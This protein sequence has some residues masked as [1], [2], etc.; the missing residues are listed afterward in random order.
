MKAEKIILGNIVTLD[1]V[2]PFAK[3]L[4]VADG[5]IQYVGSAEN[6]KALCDENT[7]V[8]DYG[9]A[10]IYPGFMDAHVHPILAGY[11]SLG[12]GDLSKIPV[13]DKEIY[14]KEIT[15]YIAEH[16]DKD[17]YLVAGWEEDANTV[18][19]AEYLDEICPDKPLLLNT[20]AGHSIL[21]N[22]AAI[23][24]YGITKEFALQQ[25]TDLVRVDD[26]GEP[27]G[28]ICEAPCAKLIE[29]L[30]I[31]SQEAKDYILHW[32][33]YAFSKGFTG[34][35][36]AGV[37]LFLSRMQDVYFDL[38]KEGALKLYTFGYMLT[39]DNISDP[40]GK[41]KE[42]AELR[43]A[44]PGEHFKIVGAK[45]FLDGIVEA[46]T[47]WLVDDYT[48]QPGYHGNERFNDPQKLT[49]L[50]AET[51]RYGLGVHAHSIGDGATRFFLDCVEAGQKLS[52][53]M[54]QRNALSHLQ[55]V[56]PEDIQ[57]MA[58]T[59]TVAVV[60]PLWS[61]TYPGSYE[62]EASYI[63]K[64]R[65]D[66]SFPIRSFFD[67]GALTVF[68]TDYPVSPS[69]DGPLSIFTAE[70]RELT[71]EEAKMAGAV[72]SRRGPQEAITRKQALLAMTLN[73]AKL[74]HQ[75]KDLGS[76]SIGKIANLTVLDRDMLND[77]PERIAC[78]QVVATVVDGNEVF[79]S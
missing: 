48:D 10:Y 1:E 43:D 66:Q 60:A 6:A 52:G 19:T 58:D 15:K 53:S 61:P 36:D 74:Y 4:T 59:N 40:A 7:Q 12:Q 55:L 16:P 41:A 21:L 11:R 65:E 30:P 73:V 25:G 42:I 44:H 79:H 51:G 34:V 22:H 29:S 76:I 5:R 69:F 13:A 54:D 72:D 64:E 2:K 77:S 57:R 24:A 68:H 17:F 18:L 8:L 38:D 45:V 62:L 78:A 67:A 26:K 50:I 47:A 9:E 20:S 70:S 71:A 56:R 14:R 35:G 37:G 49:E 33:K 27:T 32:Q 23:K 63:G 28:Y 75:E 39:A 31:T 46:H 3:A